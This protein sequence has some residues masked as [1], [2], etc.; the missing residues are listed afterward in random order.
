MRSTVLPLGQALSGCNLS[1]RLPPKIFHV[2][3]S[4][5]VREPPTVGNELSVFLI[6]HRNVKTPM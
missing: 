4:A 1:V 5:G 6:Q 3:T 2:E